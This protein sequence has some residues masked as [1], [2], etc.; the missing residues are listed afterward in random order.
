MC[1]YY[2][3]DR[4]IFGACTYELDHDI[5]NVWNPC[6][7][8][9]RIILMPM[10]LRIPA[11]MCQSCH[12]EMTTESPKTTH[13]RIALYCFM[14]HP[15]AVHPAKNSENI[16]KLTPGNQCGGPVSYDSEVGR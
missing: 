4:T 11:P 15:K 12:S 16:A 6:S 13:E 2:T 14:L 7:R 10:L 9:S 1:A 5:G 3:Q 8:A